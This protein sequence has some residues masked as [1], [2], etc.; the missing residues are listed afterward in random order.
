MLKKLGVD[1][2]DNIYQC[3]VEIG[4]CGV[5]RE[6]RIADTPGYVESPCYRLENRASRSS[7]GIWFYWMFRVAF[8]L[9]SLIRGTGF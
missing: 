4:I 2:N 7:M 5:K 6:R 8:I 1:K 9:E 3:V